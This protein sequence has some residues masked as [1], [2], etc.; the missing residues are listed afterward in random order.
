VIRIELQVVDKA[1]KISDKYK[2]YFSVVPEGF[3]DAAPEVQIDLSSNGSKVTGDTITISGNVLSGSEQGDVYIEV[4]LSEDTFS[5]AAAI[6]YTLQLDGKWSRSEPLGNNDG[7]E[8]TLKIDDLFNNV[9]NIQK[10]YVQIYE[11]D[12]DHRWTVTKWIEIRLAAC[13]GLEA[14]SEVLAAEP[15][16]Y[17]I[18]E[19]DECIWSGDYKIAFDSDGNPIVT[20]PESKTDG[21]DSGSGDLLLY[22][23]GGF[24]LVLIIILSLFFVMKGG[25]DDET[26]AYQQDFNA[27]AADYGGVAQLDPMEQYVQQLIAQGY[28]EETA[29]AYAAQYAGHFQQ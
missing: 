8:L 28:P 24:A 10:I 4:A 12:S 15:D 18:W 21:T 2:M 16:A 26:D 17:W 7:F 22:A 1:G 3:G 29:R 23:G 6:R 27:T 20:A 19:N 5:Q 11:G 25:S 13:Q 14:P 9:T